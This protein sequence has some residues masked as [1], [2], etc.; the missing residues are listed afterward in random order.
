[1]PFPRLADRAPDNLP[2]P[3]H[4]SA[5]AACKGEVTEQW[6]PVAGVTAAYAKAICWRCPVRA[7][8]LAHALEAPEDFGVWGGLDEKERR[9]LLADA[10]RLAQKQHEQEKAPSGVAS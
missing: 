3:R 2:K 8:C 9:A 1:M 7:E 5:D 4:W 10:R 6:Y